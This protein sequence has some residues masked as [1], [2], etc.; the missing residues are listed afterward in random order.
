MSQIHFHLLAYFQLSDPL[1][2]PGV[3]FLYFSVQEK[4]A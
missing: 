2:A 3:A 4:V 1:T